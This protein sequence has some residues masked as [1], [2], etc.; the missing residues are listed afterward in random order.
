MASNASKDDFMKAKLIFFY[1]TTDIE[2]WKD[3]TV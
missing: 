1:N 3:I 2:S